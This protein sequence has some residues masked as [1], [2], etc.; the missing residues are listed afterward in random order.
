MFM[1]KAPWAVDVGDDSYIYHKRGRVS[2][3]TK[4]PTAY[5]VAVSGS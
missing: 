3:N 5:D 1:H 4:S 2:V